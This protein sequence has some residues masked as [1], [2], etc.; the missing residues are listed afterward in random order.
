MTETISPEIQ[1]RM[2]EL[3]RKITGNQFAASTPIVIYRDAADIAA[4]LP[5]P[6]D[7]DLLEAREIC[8]L[9]QHPKF[10]PPDA[11]SDY[12]SG[13]FDRDTCVKRALTAIKSARRELEREGK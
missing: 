5:K 2:V 4:E 6:V 7:P 12:R 13:K 10:S 8:A 9:A 11:V 1:A 3:V